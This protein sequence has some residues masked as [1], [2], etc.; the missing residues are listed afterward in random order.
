MQN[1]DDEVVKN[2]DRKHGNILY[3]LQW[4]YLQQYFRNFPAYTVNLN[5][6]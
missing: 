4:F 2:F 5:T 3:G 1:D 6:I